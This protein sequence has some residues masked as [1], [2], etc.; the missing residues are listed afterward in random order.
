MNQQPQYQ[1]QRN[2]IES[3]FTTSDKTPLYYRH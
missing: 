2:M 3:E 1:T